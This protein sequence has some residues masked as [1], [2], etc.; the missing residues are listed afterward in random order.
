MT[1]TGFRHNHYVP[2]WYQERF[3]PADRQ[4]RELF[5]LDKTERSVR[6]SRGHRRTLPP[7]SREPLKKCFAQEDLYTLWFGGIPLTDL[8]RRFFGELDSKGRE[9]VVYWGDYAFQSI[10]DDAV[11]KLLTFMSTQK[12]RTPKGLDWLAA[13]LGTRDPTTVLAGVAQFR[14]IFNA[15]W[16]ECVWQIADAS[17]SPTKFIVSDHPVTVY[18]R[19]YPPRHPPCQRSGDPDIH[20]NGTHTIFPLSLDKVLILT[21]LSWAINPYG[22][23]AKERPHPIYEHDTFFDF[24]DI[25]L[26]RKLDEQEVRAINLIIKSRAYRYFAAAEEDWLYPERYLPKGKWSRLGGPY[27]LMPDPRSLHHGGEVGIGYEDGSTSAF[28]AYGRT[29]LHPDYGRESLPPAGRDPL[30]RFKGEFARMFGPV[31]RGWRHFDESG[32][33]TDEHHEYHLSLDARGSRKR[34]GRKRD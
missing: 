23:P 12:L 27:L 17:A 31:R 13:R 30:M 28:D 8:E 22:S 11:L 15:L 4:Q 16:T 20:L 14:M 1:T 34:R 26:G 7:V 9:A 18:N 3:L 24:T 5:C 25:Q 6:D 33:D 32:V 19:V 21:N 10:D 2:R 29:P